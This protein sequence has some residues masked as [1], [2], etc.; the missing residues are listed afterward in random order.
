[1]DEGRKRLKQE[2]NNICIDC[3]APNPQWASV[4]YGTFFCLNCSGIHRSL[5]VHISF[6]R[7]ITMDKWSDEQL[8]KME[9]GGNAKALQFF[10]S[11]PDYREGMSIKE[12]Y[13]SN[14]AKLYREKLQAECEGRVWVAPPVSQLPP[15]Q[16]TNSSFSNNNNNNNGFGNNNRA[17]SWDNFGSN[18]NKSNGFGS[19]NGFGPTG[20]FG[21]NNF[22]SNNNGFSSSNGFSNNNSNSNVFANNAQTMFIPNKAK[23]EEFFA[24]K[25]RENENRRDDIPPSQ[26]GKYTGF[27]S[28]PL[29][30]DP[31]P[32]NENLAQIQ[33]SLSSGWSFLAEKARIGVKIAAAGA[34]SLNENYI[35]PAS[36]AVR[37][38]NFTQNIGSYA[39]SFKRTVSEKASQ[40][41]GQISQAYQNFQQGGNSNR[42]S[43]RSEPYVVKNDSNNN[44]NNDNNDFFNSFGNNN[45]NNNNNQ[46]GFSRTSSN[47][48]F[49]SFN[50][51][52]NQNG[53]NRTDS[54]NSFG[55]L[56]K[57]Q[58]GFNRTDSN[59]S[60]GSFNKNNN[61]FGSNNISSLN[62][63][64]QNA[65]K[66]S[67]WEDDW[68]DF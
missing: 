5:G 29:M 8:K 63:Q 23:N 1:M 65:N 17:N 22:N 64:N 66:S 16:T 30:N 4:T 14:F 54:S 68:G 6:V 46:N 43:M 37:D 57:N 34:S 13:N 20:G 33:K 38:P 47:N 50:T 48:S 21:S 60:F 25:G 51:N 58:N 45:A 61:G 56:N 26:G 9:L 31:Q 10:Q 52:Q 67:K 11:Q 7:S 42:R 49:G 55:S 44:N 40:A 18:T 41:A 53:F 19:N 24:R 2:G 3:G 35:K 27:G 39:E 59:S 15:A 36:N 32:Q 28:T 12:K 62:N